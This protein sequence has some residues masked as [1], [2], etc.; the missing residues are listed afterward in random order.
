MFSLFGKEAAKTKITDTVFVSSIAKQNAILE[1]IRNQ[2]DSII[3]TWFEESYGQIE[4]LLLLNNLKAEIYMAREIAAHHIHNNPV[5]FFEHYPFLIKE[6]ELLEKLQLREAV[7][8]SSLDEPLLKHFGG[9]KMISLMEKMG[10]PEN[11]AIEHAMI[12]TAIRNAQ[13]KISKGLVVEHSAIS[14]AEWFSK[15]IVK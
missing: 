11:E 15:N 7:F 8:Y 10:L 6:N 14:Q 13:E 1:K 9:D 4:N 3:V 5:L 12:S 2:T